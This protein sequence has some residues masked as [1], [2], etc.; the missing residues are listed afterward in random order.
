[1]LSSYRKI[2]IA[3]NY[4]SR[5][6][7]YAYVF[8]R[9]AAHCAVAGDGWSVTHVP[10]G[11]NADEFAGGMSSE[12]ACAVASALSRRVPALDLCALASWSDDACILTATIAEVLAEGHAP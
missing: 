7:I 8:G 2:A 6:R 11:M 10:S 4:G 1:M 12:T 9:W 3:T 5:R